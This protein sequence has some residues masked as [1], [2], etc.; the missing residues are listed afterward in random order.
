MVDPAG[1]KDEA[2][3]LLR[4]LQ[5]RQNLIV[6]DNFEEVISAAPLVTRLLLGCPGTHLLVSSQ[7]PLNVDGEQLYH[8][9]SMDI[10]APA[11]EA[12]S[13]GRSDAYALFRERARAKVHDWEARSPTEIA[14]VAEILR[15][16]DG[17][18][19]AIELAAAWVGSK[20]LEEL[21]TGLGNRQKLLVRRGSTVTSRHQSMRACLDYSFGLLPDDARKVFPKLAAFAGGFFAD[22]V[23]AVCGVANADEL[24]VCLQ[25]RSLL[26][27]QEALGRSRYSMLATV[28]E[29]AAAELP[30]TVARR[31]R[32]VHARHFLETLRFAAHQLREEGS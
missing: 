17:I 8:V 9:S 1:F 16:V 20:T 29:Y 32:R 3:A 7:T 12:S 31:L 19:L 5:N 10:P 25:E 18:P 24:L 26:I 27:R 23:T 6:L 30:A 21:T 13:L 4:T 14:A 2:E 22:D 15:L 11:A 28:Q